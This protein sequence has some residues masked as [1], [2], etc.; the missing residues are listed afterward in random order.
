MTKRFPLLVVGVVVTSAVLAWQ[1]SSFWTGDYPDEAGPV[2]DDLIH[3]RIGDFL[4]GRPLMG[5][6]SLLLRAP[7]A[8][9]SLMTGGGG[10]AVLYDNAYRF[11]VFPCALAGGLLGLALFRIAERNRRGPLIAYSA[12]VICTVNPLTVKAITSGHP[13]EILATALVLAAVLLALR[14]RATAS[15]IALALAIATKQWA[16]LAAPLVII[17]LPWSAARKPVLIAAAAGVLLAIPIVA[18]NPD[19]FVSVNRD[20]LDVREGHTFP[21]S[22]WWPFTARAPGSNPVFHATPAWVGI[23]SHPLI[24]LLG[25]AVPLWFRRQ[26]R[27]NPRQAALPVLALVFLLRCALDPVDNSYYHLPFLLTLVAA[28]VLTG[29]M[30]A[31]LIATATFVLL[32]NTGSDPVIQAGVYCVFVV[33]A[34]AYLVERA[35]GRDWLDVRSRGARGRAAAPQTR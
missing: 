27:A 12:L 16:V 15:I 9:L 3:G 33:A 34:A 1:A 18:A 32:I 29:S 21:T 23:A 13:E 19:T 14:E 28:D 20:L 10:P 22:I 25:L 24:V 31:T 5:P 11:G 26:I 8:A 35:R 30:V 4:A 6:V 17:A 2:I 7:F